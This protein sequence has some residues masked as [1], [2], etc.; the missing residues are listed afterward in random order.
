MAHSSLAEPVEDAIT[1]EPQA[2]PAAC[3][4]FVRL[5]ASEKPVFHNDGEHCFRA[6]TPRGHAIQDAIEYLWRG[7][8]PTPTDQLNDILCGFRSG[9]GDVLRV[10]VVPQI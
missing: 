1:A 8:E 4:Q 9:H 10:G 5:V 6:R 3:G 7:N 2:A